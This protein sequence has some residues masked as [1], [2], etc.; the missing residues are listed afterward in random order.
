MVHNGPLFRKFYLKILQP[1]SQDASSN[2][3]LP[4]GTILPYVGNLSDIPTGWHLCDGSGGTPDLREKFLEGSAAAGNYIKAG[5][6]N[7]TGHVHLQS[8]STPFHRPPWG[9]VYE[10]AFSKTLNSSSG[11]TYY[12]QYMNSGGFTDLYFDAS[13]SNS[14]Y[15]TSETVQPPAYTV[16]YIIKIS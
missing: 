12:S 15:G 2:G 13:D 3:S 5:L 6:P 10:G 4:I 8:G 9:T 14:I 7:I 16:H 1:P 11:H